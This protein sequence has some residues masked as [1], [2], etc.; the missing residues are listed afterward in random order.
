M[1]KWINIK[2]IWSQDMAIDLGTANTL[3]V[4]KGKGVVLNEPSVVAIVNEMGKKTVLAVG[5]EAK[6]ML[7]RTPG[8][9]Q[10]IR[11]LRDGVIADFIVTEEMIKHFI[12][13]VHVKNTFA[14]PRILIC[15]PTG[16]TPVERKAIQDSALAAGARRVQLIEE[17][18]AAA[19]GA[20]LP[21]SEAT[22]SMIVDIGG[23]TTEIAVMSLG[24]VV[25]S[26][27]LRVAGDAMDGSIINYMRKKFNLLIGESTAEKIKK[28]I[29]TAIPTSNNI[30][31]MKGR[32]IR[33]G[34]PKE[35]SLT[36]ED[37]CEALMPILNQMLAAIKEA[38]ENTPPELSADLVDMGLVL[39]GGG[40]LLKNID[41]LISKDTGLPVTI[42]DNPLECVA[43]GTGKALE[44]EE[45]FST[46]LSE[47]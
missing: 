44:N 43:L 38:L 17:P 28:E 32:D 14:N 9:I 15:V 3:V 27:S 19:I 10:A 39:T 46:M 45:L 8:N 25:Y 33:T 31:L 36:E 30:F 20:G 7:G 47:Y 29:G 40:A 4:L 23:G 18:I 1:F 24:G 16:S 5:D 37:A 41:K 34:T 13:K 26:K 11:P 42:A 21:I 22:G 12:K 35:I 6:T 2:K